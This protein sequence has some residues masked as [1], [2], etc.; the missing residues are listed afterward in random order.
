MSVSYSHSYVLR[1]EQRTLNCTQFDKKSTNQYLIKL[2]IQTV[3]FGVNGF[4]ILKRSLARNQ[5]NWLITCKNETKKMVNFCFANF[6]VKLAR[7]NRALPI[8]L[9]MGK[10]TIA[11]YKN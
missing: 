10:P 4:G 11:C 2:M 3:P 6:F 8:A 7:L 1:K 5:L 9:A